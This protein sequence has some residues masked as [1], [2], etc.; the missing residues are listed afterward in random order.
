M[1][2]SCDTTRSENPLFTSSN[3][4]PFPLQ[5]FNATKSESQHS[6]IQQHLRSMHISYISRILTLTFLA[7][8]TPCSCFTHRTNSKRS[9]HFS[10][11]QSSDLDTRITADHLLQLRRVP[12]EAFR[13][14]K[15]HFSC[16]QSSYLCTCASLDQVR[17]SGLTYL[18]YIMSI[19][20]S[21]DSGRGGG[22]DD[23]GD[24]IP[25]GGDT[26]RG[27]PAVN[28]KQPPTT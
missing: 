11:R 10:Y 4:V 2:Q 14:L 19:L 12:I 23:T 21:A 28:T 16:K 24:S 25:S 6:I 8:I 27:A 13:P 7:E 22:G 1:V 5:H 26:N 3:S 9:S 17:E 20:E 15:V 18:Q